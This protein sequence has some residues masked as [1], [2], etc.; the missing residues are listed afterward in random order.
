[1]L[2]NH[3]NVYA[4]FYMLRDKSCA[5]IRKQRTKLFI[6]KS[7]KARI[8]CKHFGKI[9]M[10]REKFNLTIWNK[11]WLKLLEELEMLKK[12]RN[13]TKNYYI[14]EELLAVY[15]EQKQCA[16]IKNILLIDSE[17]RLYHLFSYKKIEIWWDIWFFLQDFYLFM[18]SGP[19]LLKFLKVSVMIQFAHML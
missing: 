14:Q 8:K 19:R 3:E 13:F 5:T 2:N 16:I 10:K 18:Q 15:L 4:T 9:A 11:I 12:T 6:S 7:F 1:M 17:T